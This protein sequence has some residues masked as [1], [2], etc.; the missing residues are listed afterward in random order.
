MPH[1]L[2]LRKCNSNDFVSKF[3]NI[4]LNQALRVYCKKFIL[5][6]CMR[7]GNSGVN[8][9]LVLRYGGHSYK[10]Q[11]QTEIQS[12]NLSAASDVRFRLNSS[13][14]SPVSY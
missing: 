6:V 1:F 12:Q 2:Y 3:K 8:Y 14:L 11:L 9:N 13:L 4:K 10:Y 7:R 5:A